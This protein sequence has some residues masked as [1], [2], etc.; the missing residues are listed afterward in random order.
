M[1]TGIKLKFK[2][3]GNRKTTMTNITFCIRLVPTAMDRS[4]YLLAKDQRAFLNGF[5]FA[6][7]CLLTSFR[8]HP[9]LPSSVH[10][11]LSSALVLSFKFFF[12]SLCICRLCCFIRFLNVFLFDMMLFCI[13]FIL[14]SDNWTKSTQAYRRTEANWRRAFEK[15]KKKN[16]NKI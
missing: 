4:V 16:E 1:L 3:I 13:K 2:W 6:M 14:N 11:F 5:Y 8:S 15:R 12:F 7:F 10:F 9:A